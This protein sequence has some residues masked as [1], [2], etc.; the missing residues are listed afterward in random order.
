MEF[1]DEGEQR[2]EDIFLGLYTPLPTNPSPHHPSKKERKTK[3]LSKHWV[4]RGRRV[5][6]WGESATR[7]VILNCFSCATVHLNQLQGLGAGERAYLLRNAVPSLV[8]RGDFHPARR[9]FVPIL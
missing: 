5:V 8:S 3:K 4:L 7:P 9:K 2:D 1:S 6:G